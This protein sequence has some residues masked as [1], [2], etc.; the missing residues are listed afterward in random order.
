MDARGYRKVISINTL[1]DKV[2]TALTTKEGISSWWAKDIEFEESRFTVRF[3]EKTDYA[4]LQ[5]AKNIPVKK[6][7]WRCSEQYFKIEGSDKTNEWVGTVIWFDLFENPDK[8]T[9]LNFFH[10]GLV[11]DLDCY[12]SC[13]TG[14]GYF[15]ES[16]KKYVESGIGTPA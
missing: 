12:K 5:I 15:L 1:A 3:N 11:E 13:E 9:T 16:L 10:E 6:V 14:W 8:T 7:A 4:V 2:Y